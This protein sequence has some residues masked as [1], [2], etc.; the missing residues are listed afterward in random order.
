MKLSNPRKKR[1]VQLK[2]RF[3]AIIKS[4]IPE[5]HLDITGALFIFP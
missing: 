1:M 4:F 5:G 3:K 2:K